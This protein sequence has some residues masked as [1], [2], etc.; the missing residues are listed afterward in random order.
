[1][2]VIIVPCGRVGFMGDWEWDSLQCDHCG[3]G[4]D[5]K[6]AEQPE[7]TESAD[8]TQPPKEE[9]VKPHT[10]D[11]NNKHLNVRAVN[12][13]LS[14]ISITPLNSTPQSKHLRC[15][16]SCLW[17]L[18]RYLL[19]HKKKHLYSL[20][21]SNSPALNVFPCCISEMCIFLHTF[22]QQQMMYCRVVQC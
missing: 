2:S 3:A 12:K 9:N 8:M 21:V 11:C 7:A 10:D 17:V 1:M 15:A 6:T 20:F 22:H 19:V 4:F 16:R 13:N 14:P 5:Q 18:F